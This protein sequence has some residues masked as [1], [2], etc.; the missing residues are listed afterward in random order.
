MRQRWHNALYGADDDLRFFL[1]VF[2]ASL[3]VY[4]LVFRPLLVLPLAQHDDYHFFVRGRTGSLFL[5]PQS[6]PLFYLGR[7]V[8]GTLASLAFPF[9]DTPSDLAYLRMITIFF[10]SVSTAFLAICLKKTDIGKLPALFAS[11][12][13]F[14][15]P[16]AQ[17]FVLL[18]VFSPLM[19]AVFFALLSATLLQKIKVND[20]LRCRLLIKPRTI[21]LI[22]SALLSLLVSVHSYPASTMFFLMPTL[23]T[24]LFTCMDKWR[25]TR[26]IVLRNL[27]FFGIV[28]LIY[29][30]AHRFITIPLLIKNYPEAAHV[31][32]GGTMY[33][34]AV[35]LDL[36]N[37]IHFF[38][39]DL[40]LK[41]FN[42]WNIYVN[43][44]I[45][46]CI[47]S[48]IAAGIAVALWKLT[49]KTAFERRHISPFLQALIF[50]V[51]LL[52]L[53]N[54][55]NL[56][57]KGGY[58]AFRTIFAYMAM[59]VI[60]LIWSVKSISNILPEEWRTNSLRCATGLLMLAGG[61][62]AQR[63]ILT[64]AVSEHLELTYLRAVVASEIEMTPPP[65]NYP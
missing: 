14:L 45:A 47:L 16:G 26:L 38:L 10:A 31:I 42:L 22:V 46:I 8:T 19:A 43:L 37:K 1:Q 40:S 57:A 49:R 56:S 61:F 11:I 27:I 23:V 4:I 34:F 32:G 41:G 59:I 33:Q 7:P 55:P 29:F 20:L 24:V 15:L 58:S 21:L 53:S 50:V 2:L 48:F 62:F 35:S 51:F 28:L 18:A 63:D 3:I 25:E 5:H 36:M 30:L 52:I 60:L 54:L 9:I 6:L 44:G 65:R 12:A 13:I 64:T 17:V 39:Y